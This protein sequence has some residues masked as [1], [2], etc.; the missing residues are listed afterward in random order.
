MGW[1]GEAGKRQREKDRIQTQVANTQQIVA[2]LILVIHIDLNVS[3]LAK[4]YAHTTGDN[5]GKRIS[6]QLANTR[7]QRLVRV[8]ALLKRRTQECLSNT[9]VHRQAYSRAHT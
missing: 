1:V 7:T 4:L 8:H 3:L 6:T 9:H 5:V 2:I